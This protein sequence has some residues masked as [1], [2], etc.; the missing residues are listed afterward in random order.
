MFSADSLKEMTVEDEG[1]AIQGKI[2]SNKSIRNKKALIAY[3]LS[4]Q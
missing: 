1:K 4:S 2:F 3:N